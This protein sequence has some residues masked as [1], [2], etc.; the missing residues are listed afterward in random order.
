MN[1]IIDKSRAALETRLRIFRS[2]RFYF[3]VV[4]I[5]DVPTSFQKAVFTTSSL[6][7]SMA[8]QKI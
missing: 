6:M 7:L 1:H 8:R 5:Q 3:F 4:L 2:T